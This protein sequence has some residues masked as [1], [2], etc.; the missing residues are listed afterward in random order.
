MIKK[1]SI[2]ALVLILLPQTALA[3]FEGH[4]EPFWF[5]PMHWLT[6]HFQGMLFIGLGIIIA[7]AYAEQKSNNR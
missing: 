5:L 4:H 2:I 3:H 6:Q 1:H 7:F